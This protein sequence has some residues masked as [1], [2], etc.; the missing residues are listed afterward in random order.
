MG[1]TART[2]S[3][4]SWLVMG[5]RMSAFC[6]ATCACRSCQELLRSCCRL[7]STALC[8]IGLRG[9]LFGMSSSGRILSAAARSRSSSLR[10]PSSMFSFSS[11]SN[12]AMLCAA[13]PGST[14]NSGWIVLMPIVARVEG[15]TPATLSQSTAWSQRKGRT[16]AY[17]A[18]VVR[19]WLAWKCSSELSTILSR[20]TS[21]EDSASGCSTVS[22]SLTGSSGCGEYC[23]RLT[24]TSMRR[25]S[26]SW[27]KGRVVSV[28]LRHSA[29]YS[30]RA[31]ACWA[32]GGE[33]MCSR[34]GR[35]DVICVSG[36]DCGVA[37]AE[38][39]GSGW[40]VQ[41]SA[42]AAQRSSSLCMEP[43]F[44]TGLRIMLTRRKR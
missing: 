16:S 26:M 23:T 33:F 22:S 21:S 39:R 35:C 30:C 6:E 1:S 34:P 5:R 42:A 24:V 29:E 32:A 15:S 8:R 9:R 14:P 38:G 44:S 11:C 13:L 37:G 19:W 31:G 12:T 36:G 17:A 28:W 2:M 40:L 20:S 3:G 27:M 10:P 7:G 25:G 4:I 41:G 18:S 43:T